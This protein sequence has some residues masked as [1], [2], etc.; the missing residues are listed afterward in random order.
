VNLATTMSPPLTLLFDKLKSYRHSDKCPNNS[1]RAPIDRPYKSHIILPYSESSES[2]TEQRPQPV[3]ATCE[4][5]YETSKQE[6]KVIRNCHTTHN[7]PIDQSNNDWL[8]GYE[9]QKWGS[10]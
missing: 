6:G 10:G 8:P 4:K 3:S 7:N 5:D 2:H 9:T 1:H